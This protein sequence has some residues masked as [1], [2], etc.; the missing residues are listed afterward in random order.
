[1]GIA[2]A[3]GCVGVV[4][5]RIHSFC[6]SVQYLPSRTALLKHRNT[7]ASE[8]GIHFKE[9]KRR[10]QMGQKGRGRGRGEGGVCAQIAPGLQHTA[11]KLQ[12][13]GGGG[14]GREEGKRAEGK[15]RRGWC[16]TGLGMS[17]IVLRQTC[18][19]K[20]KH[21]AEGRVLQTEDRG[22]KPLQTTTHKL[23]Q[24]QGRN[25]LG[26]SVQRLRHQVVLHAVGQGV[27][28]CQGRDTRNAAHRGAHT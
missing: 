15:T 9:H 19:R 10:A 27:G 11:C 20:T 4:C 6:P 25:L 1:M 3:F 13:E 14:G 16:P 26:P 23:W 24:K 22:Y 17:W 5:I 8:G 18:K 21:M 12:G 7:M 2:C 28:Q